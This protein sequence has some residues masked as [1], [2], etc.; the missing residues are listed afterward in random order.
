MWTSVR[1]CPEVIFVLGGT[2]FTFPDVDIHND[3]VTALLDA[4]TLTPPATVP[5]GQ[6]VHY[7]FM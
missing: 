6:K 2:F 1:P 7:A 3:K 4:P 5:S